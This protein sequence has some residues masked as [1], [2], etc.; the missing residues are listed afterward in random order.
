LKFVRKQLNKV[1]KK[2]RQVIDTGSVGWAFSFY[3]QEK[4]KWNLET[5]C[6][7]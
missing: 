2:K 3:Y 5:L 7:V 4:F 1:S 6:K